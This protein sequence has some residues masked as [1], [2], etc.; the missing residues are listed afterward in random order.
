LAKEIV[1]SGGLLISEYPPGTHGSSFTFPKRN[2]IIAGLSLGVVV[3]EAREKSGALITANF[4][5]IQGKKIFA[6]PGPIHAQTSK[7]CHLLIKKGAKLA[8]NANDILRELGLPEIKVNEIMGKT[9]EEKLILE[10]LKKGVLHLDQIVE[11]T[12]LPAAKVASI[13]TILE[14][15]GKIKNLGEKI[16]TT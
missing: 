10:I 2:R 5:K 8:E 14:I 15:E 12:G 11:K 9:K 7:G 16:Y 1:K 4:A 6:I 13:L 3:I